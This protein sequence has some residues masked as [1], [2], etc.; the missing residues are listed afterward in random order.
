VKR[1]FYQA[2][3][4]ALDETQATFQLRHAE[5]ELHEVR[6]RDQAQLLEEAL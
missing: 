2:G 4:L 5:L 6:A 3:R 1:T